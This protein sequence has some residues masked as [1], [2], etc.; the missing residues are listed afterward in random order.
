MTS[1]VQNID[2][3]VLPKSLQKEVTDYLASLKQKTVKSTK[4]QKRKFGY[5]KGKITLSGDF[6]SPMSEF[7]DYM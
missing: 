1:G 2:I 5:A 7:K 3:N 4:P 6:D